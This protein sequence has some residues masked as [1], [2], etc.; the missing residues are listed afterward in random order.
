MTTPLPPTGLLTDLLHDAVDAGVR[1]APCFSWLVR[2]LGDGAVQSAWHIV[3][4]RDRTAAG[5]G[6]GGVWDSGRVAGSDS[7]AV[8]FAGTPLAAGTYWWSVRVWTGGEQPGPWAASAAFRVDP[9]AFARPEPPVL[10]RE[11]AVHLEALPDGVWLADFA[12]AAFAT[13]VLHLPG[14]ARVTV[15]AGERRSQGRL[16]R[17]PP[18]TIRCRSVALDLPAGSGAVTVGLPPDKRNTTPPGVLVPAGMP[19]VAP[20]RWL[21]LEGLAAEPAGGVVMRDVLRVPLDRGAAAFRCDD[22]ALEAVWRLC[23]DTVDATTFLGVFVDGDRE[24][25]AYEGDA[26]I[27]Q[28]SHH[29]LDRCPATTRATIDHLLRFPTW[30]TEWQLHLPLMAEEDWWWTGDAGALARWR[31]DLAVRTLAELTGADGLI[32]THG[33]V[34][35]ELLRRLRLGKLADL[36]DWPPGSFTAGGTGE[37]DNHDMPPV[38]TVVNAFHVASCRA[39][40]RIDATLG[41]AADAAAWN[42]RAERTAAAINQQLWDE[43]AGAYRDGVGSAHAAQHSTLFPLAFGLVP[44]ERTERA[45]AHVVRRGMACSVYAAQHLLD[46]LYRHGRADAALD[47]MT[48]RHDRGWLRM[49]EAGST[50]TLEA[51]DWRYK[52]NLDWNHAWAS[53]PLNVCARWILGVQPLAAGAAVVGVHPQP[54]RLRRAEGRVPSMRGAVDVALRQQ[55]DSCEL[56]CTLPANMHGELSLPWRSGAAQVWLDGVRI[57]AVCRDGRIALGRVAPGRHHALVRAG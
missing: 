51:W 48:A 36:V 34:T 18:G 57:D 20:F 15:H 2:A 40:A 38:N 11:Q 56:E 7:C 27:N 54:G 17:N 8:P 30:P 9:A 35:P 49:L 24:R 21:E 16:D 26:Y 55:P 45:L 4:D 13:P 19:E 28:L 33:T 53:A 42:A 46:A 5:S 32:S 10:Q 39:M 52:N 44:A 37:R 29:A 1:P 50:M 47:L 23:A 3:V 41:R 43:A 6:R 14:A 31:D 12:R 22:V 25:I